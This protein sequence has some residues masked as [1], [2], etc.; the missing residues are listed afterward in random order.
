MTYRDLYL[1]PT[2]SVTN[3][4]PGKPPRVKVF[5]VPF[6]AT[7][8]Y[9]PG[10][11]FGP[12]AIRE[13]FLNIETYSPRLAMDAEALSI[14]DLGNLKHSAN[15]DDM[16]RAVERVTSEL[17]SSGTTPAILG[18]EHTLTYGAY[19]AVP[20][21]TSL[22]VFDAHFDLRDEYDG[23]KL[24][25]ATFLRRLIE[26]RGAESMIHV[27]G[28]AAS[29]AEWKLL[30]KIG[31]ATISTETALTV[32]SPQKLLSEF[33]QDSDQLYVTIDMDVLDPAYAPGVCS[34]EPDGLSTRQ[35]LEFLYV[36][37][38]KRI[39]GFDVVE[40]AP[41]YDNGAT[42]AA[43]AKFLAELT[44]LTHLPRSIA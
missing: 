9:R 20:E 42:A 40:V 21:H 12:N 32:A 44:C 34:P 27:G 25:H 14:E 11:K 13:A 23:F 37:K 17:V 29:E 19:S 6:D 16:I 10:S 41:H 4:L 36:L 22:L 33:L 39:V 15:I 7:S 8:S 26:K 43:A 1:T 2:P 5:G 30:E 18:G 38:G 28:R 3:I 35:V 31:L 24:G